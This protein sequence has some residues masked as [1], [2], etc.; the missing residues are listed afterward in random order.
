MNKQDFLNEL[1]SRSGHLPQNEIDERINFYAE[2]IDDYIEDGLT[3]E[4]AVRKIG[5]IDTILGQ[6]SNE[7]IGQA[8]RSNSRQKQ[9][10]PLTIVLLV[11]GSPI[12]FSLLISAFSVILSLYISLWAVIISLWATFAALVGSAFGSLLAGIWFSIG[13]HVA[14]GIAMVGAGFVCTGLAIFLFYGCKAATKGAVSLIKGP[15][16]WIKRCHAKRRSGNV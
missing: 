11:L 9:R 14:T 7:N 2:M 1:G 5:S 3:E 6:A 12:W 8:Q 16:T 13:G 15:T 4:E 10:T